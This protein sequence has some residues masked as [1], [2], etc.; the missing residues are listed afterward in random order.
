MA[1]RFRNYKQRGDWVELKFMTEAAARGLVA[2][3]PHGDFARYDAV[4]E[5]RGAFRRVQV[6]S[7]DFRN[8]FGAYCCNTTGSR[9]HR[10]TRRYSRRQVDFLALYVIPE[11]A[12]Y[13]I[14]I[15]ALNGRLSV[16]LYPHRK[17]KRSLF[18]HFREAWHLLA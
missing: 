18:E 13:I 1:P 10:A 7:T 5:G 11:D 15:D 16:L 2:I 3:R 9:N 14:P 4:V 17:S 12:W 6:K 8:R